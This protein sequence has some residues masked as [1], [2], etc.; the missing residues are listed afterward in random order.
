MWIVECLMY[1]EGPY[2]L[3]FIV[4]AKHMVHWLC[5][6]GRGLLFECVIGSSVNV[7]VTA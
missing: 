1:G 6:V 5:M 4:L 2:N 7:N 3:C